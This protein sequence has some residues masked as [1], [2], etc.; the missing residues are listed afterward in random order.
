MGAEDVDRQALNVFRMRL[1][2]AK[3]VPVESGGRT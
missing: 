2:G 1:M 3:V